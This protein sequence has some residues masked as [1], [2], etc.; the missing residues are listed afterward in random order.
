[1]SEYWYKV[2]NINPE[3]WEASEGSIG[4]KNGKTFIHFRKP[5]QLRMYQEAVA[6]AFREQNTVTPVEGDIDITFYFWRALEQYELDEG[7]RRRMHV[8]DATNLQ[9]AL[10][11][12]LQGVLYENDRN[13]RRVTS[14]IMDQGQEVTPFILI[15]VTQYKSNPLAVITRSQLEVDDPI[16]QANTREIPDVF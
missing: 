2:Q 15:R 3:P 6:S 13:N 5:T 4:R 9:K 11:D 10:E 16:A 12:A 1:M 7:K 8:A 14:E